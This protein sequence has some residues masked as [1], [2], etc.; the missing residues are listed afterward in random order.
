MIVTIHQPNF[1]PHLGFFDKILKS[2]AFIIYDTA[3]YVKGNYMNRNKINN[4]G[5]EYYITLSVKKDSW[6]HMIKD[7]ILHQNDKNYTKIFKTLD[8]LYNK[9]PFYSEIIPI[10]KHTFEIY[11]QTN[12][13]ID[14]N[15]YFIENI[16]KLF[17]WK[18]KLYYSSKLNITSIDPSQK[19]LD[20]IHKV[21]ASIYLSGISGK[22]YLDLDLFKKYNVQI[23]FQ[24]FNHPIYNTSNKFI[25]N[26][27]IIDYMFY[28]LN[29]P[30]I[31]NEN[32]TIYDTDDIVNIFRNYNNNELMPIEQATFKSL[33]HLLY[34][35]NMLDVGIG[36]GRTTSVF[37]DKVNSY[38]GIDYS[39]EMIKEAHLKFP[40]YKDK[41]VVADARNLFF[42]NNNEYDLVLFSFNG[43][44]YVSHDDRIKILKEIY[45]VTKENGY[46]ILSSHNLISNEENV[47]D[48]EN[49]E[50]YNYYIT[51]D[52]H[53][54]E[55][56]YIKPSVLVQQLNEIGF[57]TQKIYG[58]N[59]EEYIDFDNIP[60]TNHWPYYLTK[61]TINT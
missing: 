40:V 13:L 48:I 44:D 20:M 28:N 36:C 21:D 14:G 29:K 1:L 34:N 17:N 18:G 16:L 47:K 26:L 53:N 19:L 57:V 12:K 33:M 5:N 56:Y 6:K 42:V 32:Q 11:K 37:I 49:P 25:K 9:S 51:K 35:F 52:K 31:L 55:T 61:K 22:K 54:L 2:D 58:Y 15:V 10:I 24:N 7:V 30:Y 60:K 41:L 43:I 8:L 39:L 45:R 38:Y 3:Q 27:S 50:Q 46:F 4:N 59:G 23:I